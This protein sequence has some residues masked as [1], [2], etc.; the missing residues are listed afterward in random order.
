MARIHEPDYHELAKYYDLMNEKYVPYEKL[1]G[2]RG[3]ESL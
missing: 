1:A 3:G 2:K